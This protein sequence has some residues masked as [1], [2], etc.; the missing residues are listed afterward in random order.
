[1]RTEK[2]FSIPARL[3]ILD[4]IGMLLLT[5]GLIEGV[6]KIDVLPDDMRF[7]GYETAFIVAGFLLMAPLLVHVVAMVIRRARSASDGARPG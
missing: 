5:I 2:P 3:I 7:Q 4:V 6:A 1:M